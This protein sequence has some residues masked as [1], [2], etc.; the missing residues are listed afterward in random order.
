MSS[1]CE[2]KTFLIEFRKTVYYINVS[3]LLLQFQLFSISQIPLFL[4]SIFLTL[5]YDLS[6][7]AFILPSLLRCTLPLQ[8]SSTPMLLSFT[9]T[10]KSSC[11]TP[12]IRYFD[13]CSINF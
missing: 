9:P 11:C 8:P 12:L 5:P 4:A 6:S 7:A 1:I 13:K 2:L 10:P 3:L